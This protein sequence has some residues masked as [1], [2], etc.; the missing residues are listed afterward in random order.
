MDWHNEATDKFCE[1]LLTLKTKEEC[2][3]FLDDV[4]TIR[5][6]LDMSQ[7]LSVAEL[8][9]KSTSYSVIQQQTGHFSHTK[10]ISGK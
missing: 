3:Q 6:V 7:R 8:L 5:E 10:E 9:A 2:Y 1:A 4:C